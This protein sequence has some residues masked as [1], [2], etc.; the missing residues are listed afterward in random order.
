MTIAKNTQRRTT[1]SMTGSLKPPKPFAYNPYSRSDDDDDDEPG[2]DLAPIVHVDAPEF[3]STSPRYNPTSPAYTPTSPRYNPTSPRYN[4]T[5]PAYSPTPPR[6]NPTPEVIDD[7]A[8][9]EL[10]MAGVLERLAW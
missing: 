8:E 1:R 3:W 4:P 5:P 10:M 7:G 9:M 6:Y 2:S